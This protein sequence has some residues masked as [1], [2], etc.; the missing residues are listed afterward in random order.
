MAKYILGIDLGSNS[1]G[2]AALS[3]EGERPAGILASGV[4]VFAAGAAGLDRGRDESNAAARRVARLQ[5]RQTDRR[6]RRI[7]KIYN[8]IAAFGMLPPA[9]SAEGRMHALTELDQT[10]SKK[11]GA[12]EKLPYLLRALA[13]DKPLEP[14]ETGRALFHLAQR[15]GFISNRKSRKES[16]DERGKVKS[17]ITT[18][19][20]EIKGSGARTLG[21]FFARCDPRET[22][23][24]GRYTSRQMYLD[25]FDAVWSGQR[26]HHPS[27]MTDERQIQLKRAIFFQRPLRDQRDQIG[28]CD[29]EPTQKR[30]PVWHPLAQRLRLLQE[31]NHMRL[32]D[33]TGA[34]RALDREERPLVIARLECGDM[35]L[36]ELRKLLGLG[37][38]VDINLD[39]GGKKA[40]IGDRT[41][42]KMREVFQHHWDAMTGDERLEAISD[43]AGDL[44]DRSLAEKASTRWGLNELNAD[45]YPEVALETGKYLSLSLKAIGRLLPH[46]EQGCDI[47]TARKREYP[48]V[49]RTEVRDLL[50]KVDDL[51]DIRNPAVRRSL[52]ELRKVVNALIRRYGKPMEI[53]IE[54]ARELKAP[55]PERRLK[56]DRMRRL[57]DER[58][59]AA[60]RLLREVGD[61]KPSAADIE[62]WRL[63]DEC[64]WRCAYTRRGFS[65]QQLFGSG[66]I[67]VEHIIPFPLSLDDSFANKTLAYSSAN[68]LKG[69]RTPRATF[70]GTAEWDEILEEV[71][72]FKG[73][74]RDHKLKRFQWTDEQVAEMLQDFTARQMNDT[75]YASRLAAR[76][77]SCLYGGLSDASSRQ[78]VFVSPGQVTAFLR[79]LW[80]V[81]GLLSEDGKKTREDHRHHLVDAVTVALTGPKWVK[82]LAEAASQA[83]AAGRRKFASIEAPWA[84]FAEQV[85]AELDR[86]VVSMRVDRKVR[87]PLHKE[88]YYGLIGGPDGEPKTVVRKPVHALSM[89]EVARI[90]DERVRER[91]QLQL[92]L[93]QQG[94]AE[95]TRKLENNWPTLPTREGGEVS[96]KRVRICIDKKPRPVG[97][98]PRRRNVVGGDFHH[99][100]IFK[101]TDSRTGRVKF[102]R[103]AVSIQEAMERVKNHQ[104]VVRRDHGDGAEF[105]FSIAKDEV[106]EIER[107]GVRSLV[108]VRTLE[109]NDGRIGFS[110]LTDARPWIEKNKN[111]ERLTVPRLMAE[112]KCQ[113]VSVSPLGEVRYCRE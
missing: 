47:A 10:L 102:G 65:K 33:G 15:R 75:R 89:A 36:R 25:E 31:V 58:S 9:K 68:A 13:L 49:F 104:P 29:L 71:R 93:L 87:G 64:N 86:T 57:E 41:A 45:R 46:L 72:Q 28:D 83:Q 43:L 20:G 19:A 38:S 96:I 3:C 1:L 53:H 55:A 17:G 103:A 85:R 70:A 54:L 5:R 100:E 84:G 110:A 66:E 59:E 27:L 30:A 67:Q 111:R 56:W 63:A 88:T 35:P 6:R 32:V 99:F 24:R 22:R 11:F 90:V 21:E 16:D 26:V 112:L 78:R 14:F 77:V 7:G 97:A 37:R 51:K 42:E 18:L 98:G 80:S 8:M 79:R 109:A 91:V 62:K 113:K 74:M 48:E 94:G 95:N 92:N 107:Q 81:G 39:R 82:R 69:N 12:D 50:P 34:S 61:P 101:H 105:L 40:L 4:R 44:D 76:Y 106:L 60:A 2:W 108:R 73:P 23:I 52:S